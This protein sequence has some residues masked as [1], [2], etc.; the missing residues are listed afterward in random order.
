MSKS[1][2]LSLSILPAVASCFAL[3]SCTWVDPHPNTEYVSVAMIDEVEPCKRLGTAE[4][5]TLAKVGFLERNDDKVHYELL[6]LARNEAVAIGGDTLVAKTEA[7]EGRQS[8]WVYD[9]R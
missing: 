1:R 9:C 2:F 7:S 5:N 3:A 4:V 6:Q 8:F